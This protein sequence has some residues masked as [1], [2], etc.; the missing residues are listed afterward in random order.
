M[1]TTRKISILGL[2]LILV[3]CFG[4]TS[5]FAQDK[6]YILKKP[7]EW[8]LVKDL[9]DVAIYYRYQTCD[10]PSEGTHKEEVYLKVVNKT[11]KSL[12]VEWDLELHYGKKCFN[13]DGNN[14]E[15]HAKIDLK[16]KEEVAGECM[17]NAN[18]PLIIFSKMMTFEYPLSLSSFV[19]NALKVTESHSRHD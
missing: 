1:K 14:A 8:T 11:N 13:C 4:T 19:L 12:T 2:L 6:S 15:M 7:T 18:G 3:T 16:P 5:L 17:P 9:S 10:Q